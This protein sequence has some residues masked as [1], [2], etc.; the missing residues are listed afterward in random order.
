VVD[1]SG[2]PDWQCYKYKTLLLTI[3]LKNMIYGG[4][5]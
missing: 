2:D 1:L 4:D 3:P 5:A